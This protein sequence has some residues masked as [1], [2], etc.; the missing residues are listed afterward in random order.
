MTFRSKP[1]KRVCIPIH[2]KISYLQD[3]LPETEDQL[4]Y[5]YGHTLKEMC[6]QSRDH[7]QCQRG[8]HKLKPDQYDRITQMI[9]SPDKENL[10]VAQAIL[11]RLLINLRNS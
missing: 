6:I 4:I 11:L 8:K 3:S 5:R 9:E 7:L 10:N 2:D 1:T